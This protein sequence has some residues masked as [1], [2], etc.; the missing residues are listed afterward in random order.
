MDLSSTATIVLQGR[1]GGPACIAGTRPTRCSQANFELCPM[2]GCTALQAALQGLGQGLFSRPAADRQCTCSG[3]T[4][5]RQ[6]QVVKE[7]GW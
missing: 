7:G 3:L 5:C 1:F 2:G 4:L 6:G